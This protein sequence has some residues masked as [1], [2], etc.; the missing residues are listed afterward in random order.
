MASS[1]RGVQVSVRRVAPQEPPRVQPAGPPSSDA[2]ATFAEGVKGL[3][4]LAADIS[5]MFQPQPAAAEAPPAATD[6]PA[7]HTMA[8]DP[9][10]ELDWLEAEDG[11]KP[12]PVV[13]P[14]NPVG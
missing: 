2:L 11:K 12:P 7:A 4:Q 10:S 6:E 3:T 13:D 1:A 9:A 8:A 14:N 5:K